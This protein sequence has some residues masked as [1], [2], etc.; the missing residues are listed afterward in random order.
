[1][2]LKSPSEYRESYESMCENWGMKEILIYSV[3]SVFETAMYKLLCRRKGQD[4]KFDVTK[5]GCVR[6]NGTIHA[7]NDTIRN[8]EKKVKDIGEF[9][10]ILADTICYFMNA[11]YQVRCAYHEM[12]VGFDSE[13]KYPIIGAEY[14]MAIS[15]FDP[16]DYAEQMTTFTVAAQ[17]PKIESGSYINVLNQI[18]RI[19]EKYDEKFEEK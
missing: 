15:P 8:E 9:K 2:N 10:A 1:M 14:A 18:N 5:L 17:L 19:K 7:M 16:A 4:Q 6:L 11:G 13:T 3:T 12:C